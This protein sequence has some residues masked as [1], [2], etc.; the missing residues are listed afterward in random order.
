M[1]NIMVAIDTLDQSTL[2]LRALGVANSSLATEDEQHLGEL[3]LAG[4]QNDGPSHQD[5]LV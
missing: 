2:L 4:Y 1:M 5:E 3:L